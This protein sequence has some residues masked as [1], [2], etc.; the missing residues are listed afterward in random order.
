LGFIQGNGGVR[1]KIVELGGSIRMAYSAF[2]FTYDNKYVNDYL[3]KDFNAIHFEPL[4]FVRIGK[5][6]L[7]V[8]L[9]GGINFAW[10]LTSLS[11]IHFPRGIEDG[12]WQHT[13]FHLSVGLSYRF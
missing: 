12:K 13:T 9:R 5:G 1:W 3:Q 6:P 2:D 7:K 11:D 8:V 10:T 4:G